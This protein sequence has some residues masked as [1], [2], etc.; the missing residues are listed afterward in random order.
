MLRVPLVM[1]SVGRL[2]YLPL[3]LLLA[4]QQ[5]A[6]GEESITPIAGPRSTEIAKVALGERLFR[7]A[8]L[9]HGDTVSCESCH[10]LEQS[11]DD[12]RVRSAATDGLTIDFNTPTVFNAAL[13]FRLNWRGNFRTLEAHYEAVLLDKVA[14]E[15]DVARA[16]AE[17]ALRP[18]LSARF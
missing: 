6:P 17:A 15:Y 12:G 3:I 1:T 13:N 16:V 7:D 2:A 14:D 10:R 5:S 11:G 9:S 4:G 8:R 18:A